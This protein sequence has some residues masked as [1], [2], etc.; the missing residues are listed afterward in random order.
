VK[1]WDHGHPLGEETVP[2]VQHNS[3]KCWDFNPQQYGEKKG[4]VTAN[5]QKMWKILMSLSSVVF[6]E[7]ADYT[8]CYGP[9]GL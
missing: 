5:A 8:M 1:A 7:V 2:G 9:E 3:T 6:Q 4:E